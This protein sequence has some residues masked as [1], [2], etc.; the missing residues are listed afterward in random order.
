[1]QSAK[2][3]SSGGQTV[4]TPIS[5]SVAAHREVARQQATESSTDWKSHLTKYV[6][7][8]LA[9][10]LVFLVSG[11]FYVHI[12]DYAADQLRPIIA[13]T[14]VAWCIGSIAFKDSIRLHTP[15]E[16]RIMTVAE[17]LTYGEIILI[18]IVARV[19][20]ISGAYNSGWAKGILAGLSWLFTIAI[21]IAF[22][23]ITSD[24]K[25]RAQSEQIAI[26]GMQAAMQRDLRALTSND[27]LTQQ[28]TK[29]ALNRTHEELA[30]RA[31][32]QHRAQLGLEP[33]DS[34]P[35]SSED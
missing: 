22:F 12:H 4:V 15:K 13:V 35:P 11:D 6:V 9:A 10:I 5:Q 7:L 24:R 16:A 23:M 20:N 33:L 14:L 27:S 19:A 34:L 25:N 29:G 32:N 1:M 30:L 18:P 28:M 21:L 31:V 8:I 3:Q 2:L 26:G 17:W